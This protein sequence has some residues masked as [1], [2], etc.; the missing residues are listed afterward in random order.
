MTIGFMDI[1]L[2]GQGIQRTVGRTITMKYEPS[3]DVDPELLEWRLLRVEPELR[4]IVLDLA[5]VSA[6]QRSNKLG[7]VPST[8]KA[9]VDRLLFLEGLWASDNAL[10]RRAA[11]QLHNESLL[12]LILMTEKNSKSF[13]ELDKSLHLQLQAIDLRPSV[14]KKQVYD[15]MLSEFVRK[16]WAIWHSDPEVNQQMG[17]LKKNVEET[18]G[19]LKSAKSSA[20]STN[21]KYLERELEERRNQ[22]L[23]YAIEIKMRA[24]MWRGRRDL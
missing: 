20:D 14:T 10:R 17:I 2:S 16:G 23:Q 21:L 13:I 15:Q 3:F 24:K 8:H 7:S 22:F 11:E 5:T 12:S 19:K 18:E 1:C 4:N 9:D 6:M